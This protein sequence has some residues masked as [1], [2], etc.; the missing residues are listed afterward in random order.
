MTYSDESASSLTPFSGDPTGDIF[1]TQDMVARSPLTSTRVVETQSGFLIVVKDV[2]DKERLSLSVKRQIG[3]PPT[4]NI[5]MTLDESKKLSGILYQAPETAQPTRSIPN[6]PSS[7][8]ALADELEAAYA[9]PY[10]T[11]PELDT[12][13]SSATNSGSGMDLDEMRTPYRKRR[14]GLQKA[15]TSSKAEAILDA[16]ANIK[17]RQIAI[18]GTA[19][20]AVAGIIIG[21]VVL[22]TPSPG[23][24]ARK[25]KAAT[26]AA[27]VNNPDPV[28]TFA[29]NFVTNLLDFNPETYRVSQVKAM[30]AMEPE[31]MERHWQETNFPLSRRTLAKLPAGQEITINKLSKEATSAN[32]YDVEITGEIKTPGKDS[33]PIALKLSISKSEDGQF[34]VT[35]QKD[36]SSAQTETETQSQTSPSTTSE[37]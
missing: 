15:N 1:A 19:L 24:L 2:P 7:T 11:Q 21:A 37:N 23:T 3:T 16:F 27:A 29:R 4:S 5:L 22:L 17:K 25:E 34:I 32:S 12:Y 28:E 35:D 6:I 26:E 14:G 33:S 13:A 9:N 8:K 20:I 31:L 18:A 10:S 36:L 30:A